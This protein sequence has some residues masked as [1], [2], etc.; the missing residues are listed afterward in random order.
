MCNSLPEE[1]AP[2]TDCSSIKQNP[3]VFKHFYLKLIY[4]QDSEDTCQ[5]CCQP[6]CDESKRP[7]CYEPSPPPRVDP[8]IPECK[9][10]QIHA[11]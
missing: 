9:S 3:H 4:F 8:L 2:T 7:I 6:S 10:L 11:L 5:C 1:I